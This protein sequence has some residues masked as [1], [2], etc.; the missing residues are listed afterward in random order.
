M[1]LWRQNTLIFALIQYFNNDS[2][3]F[4]FVESTMSHKDAEK[5]VADVKNLTSVNAIAQLL[6]LYC[7]KD[8]N[9]IY[10]KL[11]SSIVDFFQLAK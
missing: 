1:W 3:S 8:Y 7:K 9:K 2:L 5:F 4:D 10:D 11:L 6:F